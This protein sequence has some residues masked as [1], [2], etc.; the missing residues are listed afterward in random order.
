MG[1]YEEM[2]D[3]MENNN[4][5][6]KRI[7]DIYL[8]NTMIPSKILKEILKRDLLLDAKQCLKYGLVDKILE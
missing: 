7:Q 4:A 2:K 5:L 1:K 3:D 8:E 6:M